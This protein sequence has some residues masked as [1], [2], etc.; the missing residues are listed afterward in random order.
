MRDITNCPRVAPNTICDA[1]GLRI[2]HLARTPKGI[3]ARMKTWLTTRLKTGH[4]NR[5]SQPHPACSLPGICTCG[6]RPKHE[7]AS[8][9][10]RRTAPC[11]IE[12]RI[13]I[14]SFFYADYNMLVGERTESKIWAGIGRCKAGAASLA[15]AIELA[16]DV[17]GKHH[18]G[19]QG[20]G[21]KREIRRISLAA[22][23][24]AL[25]LPEAGNLGKAP[26]WNADSVHRDG[27]RT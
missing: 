27:Y 24:A 23:T 14:A 4:S 5:T 9:G 18:T 2:R 20:P 13:P 10:R 16:L 17:E 12:L 15:L 8:S 6:G 26:L 3:R 25:P 21:Q 7:V 22:I 19:N 11:A 1:S